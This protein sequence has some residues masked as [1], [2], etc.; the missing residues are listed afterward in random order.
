MGALTS[1]PASI[2]KLA[3]LKSSPMLLAALARGAARSCRIALHGRLLVKA[4]YVKSVGMTGVAG[5][6]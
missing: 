1:A 2:R 3:S 4:E 6:A 5:I